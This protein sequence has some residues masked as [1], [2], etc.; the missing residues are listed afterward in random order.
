MSNKQISLSVGYSDAL[1]F[2]KVFKRLMLM[3]PQRY[4]QNLLSKHTDAQ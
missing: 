2:I 3:T 1:Y 4:R